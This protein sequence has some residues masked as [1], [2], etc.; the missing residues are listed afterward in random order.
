MKLVT[1]RREYDS[2]PIMSLAYL[3][4]SRTS[5]VHSSLKSSNS[6]IL[7]RSPFFFMFLSEYLKRLKDFQEILKDL[8]S[9]LKMLPT[10][11]CGSLI[12][13]FVTAI[14]YG[15]HWNLSHKNTSMNHD[16]AQWYAQHCI[17]SFWNKKKW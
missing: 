4:E 15:F 7:H 13:P 14:D 5:L 3:W 2:K 10:L 11:L 6:F 1:T 16:A 12:S 8:H 9:I 17:L